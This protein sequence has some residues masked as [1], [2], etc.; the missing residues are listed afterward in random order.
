MR[1]WKAAVEA[2][3]ATTTAAFRLLE[4]DFIV[5]VALLLLLIACEFYDGIVI[6]VDWWRKQH[7]FVSPSHH[8]LLMIFRQQLYC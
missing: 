7:G 6:C 3:L 2:K 4:K 8:T 1:T 5:V